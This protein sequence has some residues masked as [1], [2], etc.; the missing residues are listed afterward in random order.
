MPEGCPMKT[1]VTFSF[2]DALIAE[3]SEVVR[4]EHVSVRSI[5]RAFLRDLSNSARERD[6]NVASKKSE[7]SR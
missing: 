6:A 2:E 5:I 7:R 3:V 4:R 1:K